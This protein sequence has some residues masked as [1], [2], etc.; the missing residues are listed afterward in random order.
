MK[1]S[2]KW[3]TDYVD[4][5]S[6]AGEIAEKL[7]MAG[8]EVNSILS[9]GSTWDNIVIGEVIDVIPHPNAD[10][11]KLATVS[12]GTQQM[13]IVCGAHN[14]GPGQ[15]VPFARVGAQLVDGHTG[16]VMSLKPVEIRGIASEGMVCSE[17]ELGISDSHE[18]I[19]L[20]PS[21]APV[22]M[23]LQEYLGDVIFDL[24]ITPNRPDCL[25]TIGIAREIAALTG[26]KLCLPEIHYAEMEEP[27]D[28]FVTI[29]IIEPDLCPRY[30]ASLI[31][32]IKIAPSPNWLQQ[33]LRNCGMRPI[34][35]VVDVTN[36]VML[37]YGQ[38]LH[39][40]D[41][42]KLK[43]G[44]IIVRKAREGETIAT[45]DGTDRSL[46]PSV[47]VIADEERAAA[48]AGIMGG[49]DTEVTDKTTT[50]LLESANFN[51]AII[52]RACSYLNLQSEAS[53]RFDK[54]LPH[55]LPLL[56]LKRATQLLLELGDGKAVKGIIDVY[57]GKSETT[58]ILLSVEQVKRLSGL[59]VASDVMLRVL[60]SLGFE[61][62]ESDSDSTVLVRVPFWRSDVKCSADLVEEIVR[63]IGYDK[64]PITRLSSSLPEQESKL[65]PRGQ[66]SSLKKKMRSILT[67]W[68]CQEILTYSLVSLERL[69]NL[70]VD[71]ELS[72]TP[73]KVANPMTKE[74]EYLRTSLRIGLLT[75][76]AYNQKFEQAGIRL[77][78]IGKIFLPL[79]RELPQEKEMLC[80]VLSGPKSE[81]SWH[82]KQGVLDFF[83]AK[84]VAVALLD[85][86]GMRASFE[87]SKDKGLSLG[88]GADI[89]VDSHKV[90]SV[91]ELHPKIA[92]AF[93]LSGT[94]CIIEMDVTELS[95]ESI[96]S[97]RYQ[98][99]PRFP[100]VIR[101]I[102]VMLDECASYRQVEDII[103]SYPL[104]K[105]VTLFDLYT[106][107]QIPEGKKSFAIRMIYQ[108][109]SRTLTDEEVNQMQQQILE[110]LSQELDASL[111]V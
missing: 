65:S 18:G 56:P 72:V 49:L 13:T 35:N 30:C 92:R 75:T 43:G 53:I 104:V 19:M 85:Q 88:R 52:R 7:T 63:I 20:L 44:K 108:S 66:R 2:L 36:Y 83:D 67:G 51:Q 8:M 45:L 109:P 29:D 6:S 46:M 70:S 57:P 38:P 97:K 47:L 40:F 34:N 99:I 14:I 41:Y 23:P 48:V 5:K 69:Q 95:N 100:G 101:D 71:L 33:R 110:R 60:K 76:L 55:K 26:E 103:R 61:C 54:G 28:S 12:I 16:K 21:G 111:R 93:E 78:E 64:I 81:L 39:A 105:E 27:I 3:L 50:I 89:I 10:R 87:I 96:G 82:S 24:D 80:I 25:S 77:F 98:P 102:A 4:T 107:K 90:G 1:V 86:L 22:G 106:G 42:Q 84:G 11:L 58:E 15:L 68:G 59:E 32:G 62:Q 79:G 73:L 9:V 37:D 94:V 31:T 91:G 17:R 74:Q